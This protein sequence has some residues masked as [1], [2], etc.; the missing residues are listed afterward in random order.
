MLFGQGGY[1][2]DLVSFLKA[3]Y[4]LNW[5]KFMTKKANAPWSRRFLNRL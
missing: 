3:L 4:N 1:Y 5:F 2:D